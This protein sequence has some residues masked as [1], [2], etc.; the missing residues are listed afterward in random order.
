MRTT[1]LI[2][3]SIVALVGAAQ[4]QVGLG[5]TTCLIHS[6]MGGCLEESIPAGTQGSPHPAR[7]GGNDQAPATSQ[8]YS[9]TGQTGSVATSPGVTGGASITGVAG[10]GWGGFFGGLFGGYSGPSGTGSAGDTSA[11]DGW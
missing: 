10:G 7:G 2:A 3:S 5:G 8:T 9:I 11:S 6:P 4:A 1:L